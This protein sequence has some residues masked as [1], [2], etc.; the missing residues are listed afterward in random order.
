[1]LDERMQW[2]VEPGDFRVTVGASSRDLRVRGT[3][4]VR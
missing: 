4:Q 2:V 3:L 1:M